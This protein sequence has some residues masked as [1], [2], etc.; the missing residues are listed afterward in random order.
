MEKLKR[1]RIT[2]KGRKHEGIMLPSPKKEF[3]VLKLD[4]GYNVGIRK[5]GAKV[6]ELGEVKTEAQETEHRKPEAQ[7]AGKGGGEIAILGMGG[8][9]ASKVEYKTGAVFPSTSPEVL[10]SHIPGLE[11][12]CTFHAR[13]IFAMLSEDMT[14]QHWSDAAAEIRKEIDG[15]AQGVVV[16][17]GTDTMHYTSAALSFMLQELP[18]P[19]YLVGAQRS[20]DRPSTDARINMMNACFAA[21]EGPM[22]NVGICMHAGMDDEECLIHLGTKVRKMH[23]SR[24]DAFKSVNV[25]P[26]AKVDY[27]SGLIEPYMKYNERGG[28]L[29][30]ENRVNGNVALVYTYP[31]IRPEFVDSLADYDG[32]V[33][34]GTGLGHVPTNPFNAKYTRSILPNLKALVDSGIPVAMASQCIFGRVNMNVYTAGRLIEEAGVFGHLADWT[35]E[36]A[37]VKMCWVLGHEKRVER[38]REEMMRNIA[39]EITERS[40]VL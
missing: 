10:A 20:S 8:T 5:E 6:E 2:S 38:V 7:K 31:G 16:L 26:L 27:R 37:Y 4:S 36:T 29:K 28:K 33:V 19:V 18:V 23:S 35:P 39:G 34:A 25:P 15:G 3:L 21:K 12:I 1:V 24:R 40:E 30:F 14:P 13:E 11:K 22:A 17:H 9:V 32:V